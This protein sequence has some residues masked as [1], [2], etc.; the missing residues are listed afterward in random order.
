M[1]LATGLFIATMLSL[2]ACVKVEVVTDSEIEKQIDLLTQHGPWLCEGTTGEGEEA[3][4]FRSA[5]IW[6]KTGVDEATTYMQASFEVAL[7]P[8]W[9]I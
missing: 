7:A 6:T 5:Q 9:L 8:I 1:R 4:D 3:T 2:T